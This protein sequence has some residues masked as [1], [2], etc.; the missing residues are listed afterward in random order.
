MSVK[1]FLNLMASLS[2]NERELIR[3]RT[4]AGLQYARARG[5]I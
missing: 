3:E 1:L 4:N 5:R 2:E